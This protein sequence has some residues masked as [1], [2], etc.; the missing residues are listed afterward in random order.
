MKGLLVL[1]L[2]IMMISVVAAQVPQQP[3]VQD[4]EF[5]DGIFGEKDNFWNTAGDFIRDIFSAQE[6]SFVSED[7]QEELIADYQWYYINNGNLITSSTSS[8]VACSSC[9]AQDY[10]SIHYYANNEWKMAFADYW[11]KGYSS[12]NI[13]LKDSQYWTSSPGFDYIGGYYCYDMIELTQYEYKCE[14]SSDFF[15]RVYEDGDYV[16]GQSVSKCALTSSLWDEQLSDS[17]IRDVIVEEVDTCYRCSGGDLD[18]IA[19][20]GCPSGYSTSKPTCVTCYDCDVN[21][22]LDK[23]YATN[24]CPSGYTITKPACTACYS[25]DSAGELEKEYRST[26]TGDWSTTQPE[27]EVPT[28]TCYSC[29]NGQVA[30]QEVEGTICPSGTSKVEPTSCPVT[31]YTCEGEISTSDEFVGG[32]PVGWA[33]NE[34][35]C[36][37]ENKECFSCEEGNTG[38]VIKEIAP[39]CPTGFTTNELTKADCSGEDESFIDDITTWFQEEAPQSYII[40]ISAVLILGALIATLGRKP[41]SGVVSL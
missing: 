27:C 9:G 13:D 21:S 18:T 32:C 23:E 33:T 34:P 29:S 14:Q 36:T 30:E 17:Q 1:L 22:G 41:K 3:P 12:D 40:V 16:Y 2:A 19:A 11:Y 10:C 24:S 20:D 37:I 6:F 7:P 15:V 38:V 26:C 35:D 4:F 31:C 25:C 8:A 39:E 5:P 28:V